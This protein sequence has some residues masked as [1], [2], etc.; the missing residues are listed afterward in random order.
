[1]CDVSQMLMHYDRTGVNS[2]AANLLFT[3]QL[4]TTKSTNNHQ[5]HLEKSSGPEVSEWRLP[6]PSVPCMI[7]CT[8]A[9]DEAPRMSEV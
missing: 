8:L 4:T 3:L 2:T 7:R 6:S 1:M 5:T 9:S